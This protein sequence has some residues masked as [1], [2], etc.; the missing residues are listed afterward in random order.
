MHEGDHV[1]DEDD[2]CGLDCDCPPRAPHRTIPRRGWGHAPEVPVDGTNWP[3]PFAAK[4]LDI[5]ERDLR[6]LIRVV[7][8]EPAGTMKMASYRRSGRNPR[9]YEASKLI[10]LVSGVG[11]LAVDLGIQA[12]Q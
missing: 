4:T 3:L 8:L 7:G 10:K 2:D 12:R 5:P 9:V 6:D 11:S 1:W